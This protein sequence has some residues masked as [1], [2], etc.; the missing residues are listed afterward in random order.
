ME[1]LGCP[2]ASDVE[3]VDGRKIL[4]H[5]RT[6]GLALR[7]ETA[8]YRL[9]KIAAGV[10][11]R[12]VTQ[13][14]WHRPPARQRPRGPRLR[15]AFSRSGGTQVLINGAWSVPTRDIRSP[16][17]WQHLRWVEAVANLPASAF[18]HAA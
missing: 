11:L 15:A 5:H 17:D 10:G 3:G 8:T 7:G 6:G 16:P 18:P 4:D 12:H 14:I 2:A 1:L 9:G 13:I